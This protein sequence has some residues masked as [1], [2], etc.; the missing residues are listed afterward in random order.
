MSIS[1]KEAM[2]ATLATIRAQQDREHLI[3]PH[4]GHEET[5]WY[6]CV[7]YSQSSDFGDW[8]EVECG[9]CEKTYRARQRSI[10]EFETEEIK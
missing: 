9:S 2:E 4:C 3:C 6:E 5:E 1:L 8:S 10:L 7:D